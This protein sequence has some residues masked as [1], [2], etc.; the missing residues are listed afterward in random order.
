MQTVMPTFPVEDQMGAETTIP[1]PEFT[2]VADRTKFL[3]KARQFLK[4]YED[5]IT[6]HRLRRNLPL[7]LWTAT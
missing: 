3:A 1:L 2:S 4:A 6:I 7:T 5:H